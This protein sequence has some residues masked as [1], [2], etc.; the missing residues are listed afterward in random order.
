MCRW[1][2]FS[3]GPHENLVSDII[4]L[5]TDYLFVLLESAIKELKIK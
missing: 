2:L 4:Y 1:Y 5:Y 3:E